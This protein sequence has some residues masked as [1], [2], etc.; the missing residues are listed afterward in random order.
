MTNKS[1]QGKKIIVLKVKKLLTEE[2][3][4]ENLLLGSDDLTRPRERR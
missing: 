1:D 2:Q 3:L 4:T